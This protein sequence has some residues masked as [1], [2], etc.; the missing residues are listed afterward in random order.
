MRPVI[1]PYGPS[2]GA[3]LLATALHAIR[4]RTESRTYVPRRDDCVINWG[5]SGAARWPRAVNVLNHHNHVAVAA[6]KLRTFQAF[7]REG[8]PCP[9]WSTD[10]TVARRW[11]ENEGKAVCRRLLRASEGRGITV[12]S[13]LRELVNAPLYV[14]FFPKE[15]EFRVHVFRGEVID[16]TQK[17]LRNGERNRPNR[18]PYIRNSENGWVFTHQNVHLSQ[19]AREAAIRA[20]RSVGLDFGAVDLAVNRRGTVA[21]FEVNTA[22]GIEGTTVEHY[23]R[24]IQRFCRT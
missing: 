17:R 7:S 10:I 12:A 22:P 20:V 24:A 21:V 11:I 16:V 4:V 1:W 3:R 6:D 8:V 2:T 14:K 5:N 9:E 23:A 15:T 13:T 18:N 19:Q